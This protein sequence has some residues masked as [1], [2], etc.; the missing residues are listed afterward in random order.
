[1]CGPRGRCARTSP[2][3]AEAA[4]GEAG[5][6][7]GG[8]GSEAREVGCRGAAVGA[9]LEPHED[10]CEARRVLS[11]RAGRAGRGA[12]G[13]R[14]RAVAATAHPP[15]RRRSSRHRSPW[16]AVEGQH[17]RREKQA[18]AADQWPATASCHCIRMSCAA[19]W[20]TCRRARWCP[21]IRGPS[22][23][24]RRSASELR[25]R[26]RTCSCCWAARN[27]VVRSAENHHAG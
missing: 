4:G 12:V 8:V 1:V 19:C 20:T 3:G 23:G 26:L 2:G 7:A 24:R 16:A 22:L 27:V 5:G 10:T 25:R 17:P 18:A 9:A 6:G 14:V 21:L 11:A 13:H 15:T